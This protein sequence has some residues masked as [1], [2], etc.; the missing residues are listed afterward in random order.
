[1]PSRVLAPLRRSGQGGALAGQPQQRCGGAGHAGRAMHARYPADKQRVGAV[2][3]GQVYRTVD[4]SRCTRQPR[5][6]L[7]V[8]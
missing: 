3:G 8:V 5:Q 6:Q 7:G 1:M 4:D 2:A